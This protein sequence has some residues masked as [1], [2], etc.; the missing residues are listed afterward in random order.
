M[1]KLLIKLKAFGTALRGFILKRFKKTDLILL[2]IFTLGFIVRFYNLGSVP[3]S[4]NRDE[5]AIGYNAYSILKTGRDEWGK[6]FPLSF[7]SFGDYKSPLYIYFTSMAI[8]VFGLNEFSVRFWAAFTGGLTVLMVYFLTKELFKSS[9][10]S[11]RLGKLTGLMASFLLA[12]SPWHI[13]FS[14]FSFE[15]ILA[16]F[17]NVLILFL[18]VKNR[19]RKINLLIILFFLLTFFTYS[20]SLVI[21]PIF[22]I[23]WGFFI[24]INFFQKKKGFFGKQIIG[25]IVILIVFGLVLLSQ[26][27]VS[28]QKKRVTIFGDPQIALNIYDKQLKM[29]AESSLKAKLFYNQYLA[30]GKIFLQNYLKSFSPNFLFGGGGTHPWHK[31]PQTPHFYL[32]LGFLSLV[33]L[34]LFIKSKEIKKENKFFLTVFFILTPIASALT[35]DAPH[36]TRLLNMFLILIF[37]SALGLTFLLRKVKFLGYIALFVLLVNFFQFTKSYFIDYRKNPPSELQPGLKEALVYL[38]GYETE[39]EEIVFNISS[40]GAY[41]YLLFYR[42]YPPLE[43]SQEVKRYSGYPVGLE[44]VE[45][46]DKYIFVDNPLPNDKLKQIYVLKGDKTL[47]KRVITKIKSKFNNEV[48][49]TLSANF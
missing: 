13:F 31:I 38:K 42:A 32:I 40:D 19:F 28:K 45:K 43:F 21:W 35:V 8:A 3:A 12:I 6:R 22:V 30:Y 24:L 1:E 23:A 41:A 33:G 2:F 48:Y 15:A 10:K 11:F 29:A 9:E 17:F 27:A 46:F 49:Y 14:R 37:L 18:L 36:A 39:A 16:L 34:M 26:S 20:S 5:P 47:D 4:F 7:K 25:L 44:W